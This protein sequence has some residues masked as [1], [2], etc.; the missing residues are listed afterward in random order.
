[1]HCWTLDTL[2]LWVPCIRHSVH[3]PLLLMNALVSMSGSNKPPVMTLCGPSRS[4]IDVGDREAGTCTD[5]Y[6]LV[7]GLRREVRVRRGAPSR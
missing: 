7:Q 2:R 4:Y 1:M 6:D 5:Q 3:L